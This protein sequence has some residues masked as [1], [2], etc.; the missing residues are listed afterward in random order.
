MQ[1]VSGAG[2]AGRDVAEAQFQYEVCYKCHSVRNVADAVVDRVT[3]VNDVAREFAPS[4]ASFHPVQ[5]QGR[6]MDVPSLV[7]DLHPTSRIYCTDCHGSDASSRA[8]GPHGSPFEPLL[9][10]NYTVTDRT[11][12]SP[13][14]YEL[15]YGCHTRTSVLANESFALHS[16]HVVD[17]QTPCSA[18][19]D[20]HGVLEN[21]HLINFDRFIVKPSAAGAGPTFRSLGPRRGSC[22]LKCHGEDH[23]DERYP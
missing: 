11:G 23:N 4:N 21:A 12:E 16:K 1:G 3:G 7:K 8:K 9:V 18:C 19:H 5:T 2:G 22:T 10:R 13:Q 15:C 20:S 17:E 14:A 6:N